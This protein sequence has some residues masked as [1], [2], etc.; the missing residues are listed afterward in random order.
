MKTIEGSITDK[1]YHG[2]ATRYKNG[3]RNLINF[4]KDEKCLIPTSCLFWS[5]DIQV[6]CTMQTRSSTKKT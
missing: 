6:D 3:K 5:E 2:C 4:E 1:I